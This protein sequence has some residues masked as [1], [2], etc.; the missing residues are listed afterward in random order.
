MPKILDLPR[1]KYPNIYIHIHIIYI[2]IY[3]WRKKKINKINSLA[4][5]LEHLC[6]VSGSISKE[7]RGKLMLSKYGATWLNQPV[8]S[9][10]YPN[11]KLP[12]E[13]LRPWFVA[14]NKWHWVVLSAQE[15]RH[16][17]IFSAKKKHRTPFF[18]A[19]RWNFTR[20]YLEP[21]RIYVLSKQVEPNG[22]PPVA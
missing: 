15:P 12:P 22:T 3:L 8:Y 2:Y 13:Q 21:A 4:G 7:R 16:E 5:P 17:D 10:P 20:F 11:L 18:I 19:R 9:L 6:Q 14:R 1:P